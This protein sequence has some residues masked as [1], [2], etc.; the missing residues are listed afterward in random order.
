MLD[1]RRPW[2][3]FKCWL[4][5]WV[6]NSRTIKDKQK[7]K[8]EKEREKKC[9]WHGS[10]NNIDNNNNSTYWI[11]SISLA[12]SFGAF[13]IW[14]HPYNMVRLELIFLFLIEL[15]FFNFIGVYFIYNV[16]LSG[17]QQSESVKHIYKI[18]FF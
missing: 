14:Y 2:M 5:F 10:N 15:F 9:S 3:E 13:Y 4:L 7:Y 1:L 16:L 12:G 18:P 11:Y 6:L 17:I 8:F